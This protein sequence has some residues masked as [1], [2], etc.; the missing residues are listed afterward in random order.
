MAPTQLKQNNLECIE[1]DKQFFIVIVNNKENKLTKI[2]AKGELKKK[3]SVSA[4]AFS[5]AAKIAI[6]KNGGSIEVIG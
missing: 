2:L 4:H 5:N 6:E 1:F 3:L